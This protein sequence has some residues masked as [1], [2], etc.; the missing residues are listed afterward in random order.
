[1]HPTWLGT[2]HCPQ[3]AKRASADD[4]TEGISGQDT[5]E[6]RQNTLETFPEVPG[7]GEQGKLHYRALQEFF[8]IRPLPS[9]AGDVAD[10]PN[11]QQQTQGGRQNEDTEECVPNERTGQYHNKRPK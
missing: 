9:R 10:L 5:T 8:F 4:W 3:Q 7:F 11:V 1:M 6:H 2:K